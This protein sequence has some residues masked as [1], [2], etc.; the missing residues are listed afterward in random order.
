MSGE[1]NTEPAIS[2]PRA[3]FQA[4]QEMLKRE[5]LVDIKW[6]TAD[7][8]FV[9]VDDFIREDMAIDEAIEEGRLSPIPDD[10]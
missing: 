9:T 7:V 5:G 6:S 1:Q 2:K 4:R 8:T 3:A 10:L